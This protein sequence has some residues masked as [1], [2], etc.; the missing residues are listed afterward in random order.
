MSLLEAKSSADAVL[1]PPKRILTQDMET[2]D[3]NQESPASKASE[4]NPLIFSNQLVLPLGLLFCNQLIAEKLRFPSP[5]LLPLLQPSSANSDL[6]LLLPL[7]LRKPLFLQRSKMKGKKSLRKN[8]SQKEKV[9]K[10]E[11]KYR[12]DTKALVEEATSTVS[13]LTYSRVEIEWVGWMFDKSDKVGFREDLGLG[14]EDDELLVPPP[15]CKKEV[16]QE[17]VDKW[18]AAGL[19]NP[20][21]LQAQGCGSVSERVLGYPEEVVLKEEKLKEDIVA[22]AST[23]DVFNMKGSVEDSDWEGLTNLVPEL[24]T[25]P[26][27]KALATTFDFLFRTAVKHRKLPDSLQLHQWFIAAKTRH[28]EGKPH[29]PVCFEAVSDTHIGK[30]RI[31]EGDMFAL[32]NFLNVEEKFDYRNCLLFFLQRIM[33]HELAQ[34]SKDCNRIACQEVVKISVFF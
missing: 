26:A 10:E 14:E 9:A 3:R 19:I 22:L 6:S 11:E 28:R 5:L 16:V 33:P 24:K 31:I 4:D 29:Q 1:T 17:F 32:S 13:G 25:A 7:T 18:K 8:V 21:A 15:F 34:F 2:Q 30:A 12:E 20:E 23:V 27:Q